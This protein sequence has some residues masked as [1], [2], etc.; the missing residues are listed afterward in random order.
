MFAIAED[1][2]LSRGGAAFP[3][4]W[5]ACIS[6]LVATLAMPCRGQPGSQLP[7]VLLVERPGKTS[8]ND[9]LY[10]AIRAQLSAS[11]VI[12]ERIELD[13]D[14]PLRSQ[15]NA[16]DLAS[17]YRASMVFWMDIGETCV[18]YFYLPDPSGGRISSRTIDLD[19]DSRYS[20]FEVIA[21]IASSMI[22]GLLVSRNLAPPV[23][24]RPKE[25][26]PETKP[27]DTD[28]HRQ[29]AEIFLAYSGAVLATDVVTHGGTLGIGLFPIERLVA[30]TSFTHSTP[31]HFVNEE[32]RLRVVSRQIEVLAA[33]RL[34]IRPVDVRVGIAWSAD[35]RSLTTAPRTTTIDPRPDKSIWVHSLEPLLFAAWTYKDRFGLFGRIGVSLALNETVYRVTRFEGPTGAFTPFIAKWSYQFGLLV[36]I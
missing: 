23:P 8:L 19:L 32:L 14:E 4:G 2:I 26:P 9:S 10:K 3:A 16:F 13:G 24:R 1:T 34:L 17:R 20:R 31:Q 11:P 35:L 12:L 25:P 28:D 22:E 7:K 29:W 15:R 36:R 21:V 33:G 30:A 6:M 27:K 5:V 18:M